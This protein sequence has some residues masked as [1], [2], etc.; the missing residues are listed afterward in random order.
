LLVT[1]FTSELNVT[2]YTTENGYLTDQRNYQCVDC[3]ECPLKPHCT[4]AKGNRSI[5]IS[6]SLKADREQARNNL[7]SERV[8]RLRAEG[9]TEVETVFGHIKHNMGFRRCML[10]GTE[11]VNIEWGLIS[12]AYNLSKMA[13]L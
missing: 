10:R 9:S 2:R 8:V 4:K 5:R 13:A 3:Q 6:F 1:A 11:K 12:F 7:T